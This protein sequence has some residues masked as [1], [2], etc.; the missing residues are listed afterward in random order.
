MRF[1]SGALLA[2]FLVKNA[3]ADVAPMNA[4]L[5]AP[6]IVAPRVEAQAPVLEQAMGLS[7]AARFSLDYKSDVVSG[8]RGAS[9]AKPVFLGALDLGVDVDFGKL[10]AAAQG[11]TAHVEGSLA[12]GQAPADRIGDL[13]GTDGI[14]APHAT[15][16][17]QA[18]LQQNLWSDR[19]SLLAGLHDLGSEFY[20]NDSAAVFLNSSFGIGPELARSGKA[21]PSTWPTTALGGRVRVRPSEEFQV[22]AAVYD[23]VPGDPENPQNTTVMLNE[24]DGVMGIAEL[25]ALP[26]INGLTGKYALGAW[27][28]SRALDDLSDTD[29]NGVPL[30]A[31]SSGVYLI[32]D[33]RLYSPV[34]GEA[35][36]LSGFLRVGWASASTD[37][38]EYAM[39]SGFVYTGLLPG[40]DEDQLGLGVAIARA[41][42]HYR[43]AMVLKSAEIGWYEA[44][45]ELTYRLKLAP[46]LQLQPDVQYILSPSMNPAVADAF[47]TT[48]RMEV[49]F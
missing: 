7:K 13:Q 28:Y 39:Q 3:F 19:F 38:I 48:G 34:A 12:Y 31:K 14:S 4:A 9:S 35:R 45:F 20:A 16:L 11:L 30:K 22:S 36:G 37:P 42:S 24:D 33:Q 2:A 18:W 25:A 5:A 44:A 23:G 26:K 40:R 27:A 15:K 17:Y 6:A 8:L 47:V 49:A 29:E 46:W 41:G 32:A 1:G 21:G 10:L 43:T